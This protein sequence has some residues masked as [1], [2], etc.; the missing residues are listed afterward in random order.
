MWFFKKQ[1][2]PKEKELPEILKLYKERNPEK[3][4]EKEQELLKQFQ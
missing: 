1:V 3:F 2:A 4:K